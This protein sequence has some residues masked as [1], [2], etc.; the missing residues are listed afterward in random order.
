IWTY[1]GT[2]SYN[3]L[4]TQLRRRSGRLQWNVNY[5]WSRTIIYSFNQWV[6]TKLGKNVTNRPHAVNLNFWYEL[7]RRS[8][9][10]RNA[11]TR[12]ALDGWKISGGGGIYSGTPFT[13]SCGAQNQIPGYWTGTPTG[14]VPF[15]CQMGNNIFLPQGQNPSATEDPRLQWSLNPAN[16]TL[17]S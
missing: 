15:R 13:V 16:F 2:N 11:F 3:S 10:W 7:P 8:H 12:Q 6:D 14:G 1:I 4:Q 17:P 5:T 9:A